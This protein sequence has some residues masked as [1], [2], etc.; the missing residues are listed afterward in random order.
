MKNTVCTALMLLMSV[1]MYAQELYGEYEK[2]VYVSSQGDSLKYR[3]L[4]PEAE[5]AGKKYPLVLFLHGAGERG[6]D[7]QK[8][9][10]HG[11]QM[12]LNPVNREE[13]P[14]FVLAPQ[15]PKEDYWAYVGRPK[16]FVPGEMPEVQEPTRIFRTLK[17]L[18][19]T[20]LAMPQVD[21]D[22][23]YVMGLSMGGMGTFDLAIRYPEVFA[24]A[25][26]ICGIVNPAR[27]SAAKDVKFRIYHGDADNIVPVEGSRQA[28]KA[29]KAAG[30]DVDI[31]VITLIGVTNIF[32]TIT[33][34]MELRQK[35]F[36]MLKSIGMTK[37]EF[38]RMINLETLF[39]GT[40][41]LLYGIILGLLGTL[42]MYKA[43]SVKIDAGMYIPIKPIIISVIFVFI[44]IFIIMRY[45]ISKINKQNTIETIRKDNI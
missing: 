1:C 14:A 26:P 33:S 25:V 32:N 22:R 34:N 27:L 41:S 28:Y 24:A 15:C 31:A 38:N 30:A 44:L 21:K 29:L 43:F 18:L 23:I 39:Y 3:L 20:Y 40:K 35:E 37:K 5:K 42:A 10:V 2:K 6:D 7:N 4:R 17:E 11:G 45:S 9:L 13:Y 36:A 16:S 19:D 8:Q 12:W